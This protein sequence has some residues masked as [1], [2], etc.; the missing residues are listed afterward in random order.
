MRVRALIVASIAWMAAASVANAQDHQDLPPR[1]A[2][3]GALAAA[4]HESPARRLFEA[5]FMTSTVYF[6]VE[7]ETYAALMQAK[8]EGRTSTDGVPIQFWAVEPQPGVRALAVY[9]SEDG[10]NRDHAGHHWL[11]L[12]GRNVLIF[13]RAN[14]VGVWATAAN[15]DVRGGGDSVT[16]TMADIDGILARNPPPQAAPEP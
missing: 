3:E 11:S 2:A 16:W 1:N 4:V 14:G 8:A 10:F 12:P 6:R 9:L 15:S 5:E 7:A 13:A